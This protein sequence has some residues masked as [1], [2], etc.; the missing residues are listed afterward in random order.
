MTHFGGY[1]VRVSGSELRFSAAHFIY[2][3]VFKE[4]LHGHNYELDVE[5]TGDL[6]GDGFVV[7][8]LE[9]KESAKKVIRDLDHRVLLPSLNPL[10]KLSV[11]EEGNGNVRVVCSGGEEYLFPKSDVALL[12]IKDTSSEELAKHLASKIWSDLSSQRANVSGLYL[13]LNETS[14]YSAAVAYGT[15]TCRPGEE[16]HSSSQ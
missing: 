15:S 3:A 6:G 13:R 11:T 5:V 2:N 14:S 16:R 1:S 4:P 12:P 10:L 8:F 9:L 7:N